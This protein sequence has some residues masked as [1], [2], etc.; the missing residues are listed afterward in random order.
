V[1]RSRAEELLRESLR[2]AR[3]AGLGTQELLTL[4]RKLVRNE[5]DGR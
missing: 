3:E 4:V 1:K 2:E 5:G